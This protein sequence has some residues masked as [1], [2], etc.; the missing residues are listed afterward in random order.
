MSKSRLFFYGSNATVYGLMWPRS[1]Y[2]IYLQG[3]WRWCNYTSFFFILTLTIIPI[4]LPC[5]IFTQ[6]SLNHS[7][8][9]VDT[10]VHT[11]HHTPWVQHI[12][13]LQRHSRDT[14]VCH[15]WLISLWSLDK[16][17]L[18][19]ATSWKVISCL[20]R[21]APYYLTFGKSHRLYHMKLYLLLFPIL[22]V[23]IFL[24][25]V[26]HPLYIEHVWWAMQVQT[27]KKV[28]TSCH[29]L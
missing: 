25:H 7:G 5:I 24:N 17:K 6:V 20:R 8:T 21:S 16:W 23:F 27:L 4:F 9:A 3:A 14:S 22:H 10:E 2:V 11:S 12:I 1:S 26:L 13:F 28:L 18:H 29:A 19:G 15:L